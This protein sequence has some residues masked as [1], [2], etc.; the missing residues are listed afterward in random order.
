MAWIA[1]RR[2]VDPALADTALFVAAQN[3]DA[4]LFDAM[5][6]ALRTSAN[7]IDGRNLMVALLSFRD[8][9]LSQRALGMLLDP[10]LDVRDVA[11]ALGIAT[12]IGPPSRA[13]HDFIVAHFDALAARVDR[14]APATWPYYAAALCSSGDRAA[15]EAFWHPRAARYAGAERNLANTLEAIDAC[16]RLRARE[17]A[18][19]DAYLARS[20]RSVNASRGAS[21][22]SSN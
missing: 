11:T 10:T 1:D 5:M 4:R 17:A 13:P 3:G 2:A 14:D 8:P 21:R 9:S 12:G 20:L 7:G 18:N 6:H 22:S 19:V 15:V 16:A